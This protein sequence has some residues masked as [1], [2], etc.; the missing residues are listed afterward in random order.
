MGALQSDIVV[1]KYVAADHARVIDLFKSGIN[2]N[3][4]APHPHIDNE[5]L[6]R[7]KLSVNGYTEAVIADDLNRIEQVY[8]TNAQH[9]AP[10]CG[11]FWV[12]EDSSRLDTAQSPLVAMVALKA[13]GDKSTCELLRMCVSKEVRGTGLAMQMI[14]VLEK[15]AKDV[16]FGKIVLETLSVFDRACRFYEKV[17]YKRVGQ[18]QLSTFDME[19]VAI[20]LYE[21]VI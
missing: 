4:D 19:V 12:A 11:G 5:T 3:L 16:G 7:I 17:G 1:R 10:Y 20:V 8:D 6:N 18:R 21:K 13:W 9:N 2:S 14:E 15:H